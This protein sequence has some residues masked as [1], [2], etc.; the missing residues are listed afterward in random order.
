MV[1]NT[2]QDTVAEE[3]SFVIDITGEVCPLTF[4]RTKLLLERMGSGQ[5]A[6]IRLKVGEPLQ[7]IPR[8]L[9]A[10]GHSLLSIIPEDNAVEN[11]TVYRVR[12][13]KV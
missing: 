3:S 8:Q 9:E 10:L 4:V 2:S 7:N 5:V 6:E 1:Q 13:R 11:A 12:V